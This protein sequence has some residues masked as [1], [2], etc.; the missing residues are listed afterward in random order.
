M[1]RAVGTTFL[2]VAR[3]ASN[4]QRGRTAPHGR[5]HR[6]LRRSHD[7]SRPSPFQPPRTQFR[8]DA[9]ARATPR[10]NKNPRPLTEAG[11]WVIQRTV[12]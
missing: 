12:G 5:S 2:E 4:Q 1:L 8:E 10:D 9:S 3:Q 11:M 6:P 7:C